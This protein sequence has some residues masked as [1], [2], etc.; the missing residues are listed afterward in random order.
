MN[1]YDITLTILILVIFLILCLAPLLSL[2]TQNIR[3]NW[4][5]YRCNPIMLPFAGMFGEDASTNF[6]YCIHSITKDFIGFL[7]IPIQEALSVVKDI[8]GGFGT[9]LNDIRKVIS[10]IRSFVTEIV[11]TIFGVLLNIL[12]DFQKII[13]SLKDL[14]AKFIGIITTLLY[15][16]MGT[17]YAM[18]SAWHG[19]PGDLARALCFDPRTHIYLKN[20]TLK[21]MQQIKLGD[22]LKDGSVVEGILVLKNTTNAPFYKFSKGGENNQDILV[23]GSHMVQNNEEEW[24]PVSK[25][26]DSNLQELSSPTLF[27]LITSKQRICIGKYT[28]WD[29]NDDEIVKGK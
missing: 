12:I 22:V 23:T 5:K 29:W 18:K 6:N 28:F 17:M 15:M 24:I 27:S 2:G 16:I 25:H 4:V 26:P 21:E 11:Q 13:I 1:G 7:L 10:S 3:D 19:P 9:A 20:G 14:I 8:S